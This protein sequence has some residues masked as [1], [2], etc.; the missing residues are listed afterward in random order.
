MYEHCGSAKTKQNK[1]TMG[2]VLATQSNGFPFDT[3]YQLF[4]IM[5][6]LDASYS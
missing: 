2:A 6:P 4:K 1:K 3:L 5:S